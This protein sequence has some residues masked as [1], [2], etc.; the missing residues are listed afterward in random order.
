MDVS[1]D[2]KNTKGDHIMVA[3]SYYDAET[4]SVFT[5]NPLVLTLVFYDVA[6]VRKSGNGYVGYK[7][8]ATISDILA[9]FML[10]NDDAVLCF[11]CD[12]DTD[13]LRHNGDMLP[14]EYRSLLFS[15]MFDIYMQRHKSSNFINH[16]VEIIDA[17]NHLNKQYAHFICRYEH[18]DAVIC[19][20]KLIME[21]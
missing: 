8:L 14:Q 13:V 9:N 20:G 21:K 19:L 18:K 17:N 7:M 15:R 5:T 2:I 16:R 3:L 12:P 6:L 1:F 11:Y 4:I 10:E